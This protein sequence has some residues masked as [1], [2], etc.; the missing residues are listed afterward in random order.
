MK[1]IGVYPGSDKNYN[2]D[3]SLLRVIMCFAV[4]CAHCW[5]AEERNIFVSCWERLIGYAVPTFIL[6]SFFLTH[7][8]FKENNKNKIKNR[9][10]RLMIPQVGWAVI[11]WV[12]Y[13]A[14]DMIFDLGFEVRVSDAFWQILTGHSPA[15]NETMWFQADLIIL[16]GLF[17]LTFAICKGYY[18]ICLNTYAVLALYIQ[19]SGLNLFL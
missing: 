12:I 19:Y 6:M 5:H 10:C 14:L 11:Y 18:M 2:I 8:F 17:L 13:K 16:T 1:E 9:F 4:V 7:E 15:L 3:L